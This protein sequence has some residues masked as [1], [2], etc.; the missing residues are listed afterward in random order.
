MVV[1][2]SWDEFEGIFWFIDGRCGRHG[3]DG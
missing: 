1:R 2:S 3:E